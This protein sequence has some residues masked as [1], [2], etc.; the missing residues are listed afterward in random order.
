MPLTTRIVT[1]FSAQTQIKFFA[2][3]QLPGNFSVNGTI[4]STSGPEVQA[5]YQATN[6]EIAPSLGRNLAAGIRGT[7]VVPSINSSTWAFTFSRPRPPTRL[8]QSLSASRPTGLEQHGHAGARSE[9]GG[10]APRQ[11][12]SG[13]VVDRA[14]KR[15]PVEQAPD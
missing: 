15:V 10:H 13:E 11:D 6:A 14:D 12:P 4:R 8:G 7:A 1:P 9:P 5:N 3:Y 2:M